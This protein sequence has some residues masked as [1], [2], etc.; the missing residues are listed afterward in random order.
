[1]GA[2]AAEVESCMCFLVGIFSTG[3][4]AKVAPAMALGLLVRVFARAF[5]FVICCLLMCGALPPTFL[6]RITLGQLLHSYI[7]LYVCMLL[8]DL[9]FG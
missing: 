6:K 7:S 5:C 9:V 1:M 4:L 3:A 8:V 2:R